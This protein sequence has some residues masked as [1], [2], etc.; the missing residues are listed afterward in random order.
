MLQRIITGV[1]SAALLLVVLLVRGWLFDL[2]VTFVALL[3]CYEM[4]R[5][6]LKAGLHPARWT[7]YGMVVLMLP[8]YLLMGI[9]GV[10]ILAC[11]A[12]MIIMLQIALR[13]HPHWIDAAASLNILI[14]VPIP[15]S[16]LHPMIRIQPEGLGVLL[17]FSVFVIALVGD[18]FAY[19]VGVTVGKHRM[20]PELSP[21]KT[22]EGSAAGLLGSVVG[23]ILLCTSGSIVTPMPPV[24]HFLLLG[25]I[26]GVA[27][28]LGDLSASLIKRFC[29]IKDFGTI[30]PGHGGMMDRLDS[31]IFVIYILFG[32][33]MLMGMLG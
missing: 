5:A 20:A 6:F 19:F 25:I 31:V 9:V 27:G 1:V 28:Q 3:G 21:K 26:G 8:I 18:I 24:W 4:E 16:M 2:A 10:Y 32:Y 33:C 13:K 29:D 12:T 11:G 22:W 15:L 23:A 7:V 14:S 17:V 30:F